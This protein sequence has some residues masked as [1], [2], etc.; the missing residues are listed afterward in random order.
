M[1]TPAQSA[2]I[3]VN[4]PLPGRA[5]DVIIGSGLI[6]GAGP[7]IAEVCGVRRAIVV[8]DDAVA[9]LYLETLMR[10]LTAAGI[11][12]ETYVVRQGEGSKSST[13]LMEVVE[14]I[15]AAR[16]ERRDLVIALG[17]GVVGDLAGFAAAIARRGMPFVQVPT[18]LLAQV[19]SAV[20]GKTGINSPHGKNLIGAFHQPALVLADT[21]ALD[22]LPMRHRRAGYAEIAKAGLINDA[23]FFARLEALGADVLTTDLAETIATAVRIKAAVVLADE[24]EAGERALLNLG[25][26]F[27]HAI[28]QGAGYDGRIVHGEAVALGI[29]LAFRLSAKLGLARDVDCARVVS[30]FAAVGL[31]TRFD[32]LPVRFGALQIQG[33]MAQ[34]KKVMDGV[35]RFVLVRGI[36]EAFVS[37]GVAPDTIAAFLKDEGLPS[38]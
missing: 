23:A 4:V 11:L 17:G 31:P 16:L 21:G 28:E 34:D 24:T 14:A 33:A 9:S 12:A 18:T 5:Y 35:I 19:D 26:T 22:T 8:S 6:E 13:V 20:G 36:G 10:S 30:H 38:S 27:A 25:H 15:L 2:P 37:D 29:C 1:L 3:A 32:D 7:R